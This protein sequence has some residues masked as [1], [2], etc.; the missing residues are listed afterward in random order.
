M[1]PVSLFARA[2]ED[3]GAVMAAVDRRALG[4]PTPCTE[5]TVQDLMD[6]LAGSTRYL[7][8]GAGSVW[9]LPSEPI[10]A[11]SYGAGRA[12]AL[13]ALAETGALDRTCTSPLGFGW[14][15]AQATM[16]A[17]MD[18]LVH[19]WDLAVAIGHDPILDRALVDACIEAFLPDMPERGR[20]GG[21]VGPA[22]VVPPDAS[23]QA[24]LLAAMG[25]QPD[26]AAV[27]A[28]P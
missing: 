16:G 11:A 9:P 5:W 20:A 14:S 8:E 19:T 3:A 15:V 21:L 22:V 10:T 7:V 1:D 28:R 23:P 4:W 12:A 24:R 6:H 18:T 27:G 25:R 17:F 13:A 26:W 2:T